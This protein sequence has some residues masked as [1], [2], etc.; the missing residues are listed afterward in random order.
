MIFAVPAAGDWFVYKYWIEDRIYYVVRVDVGGLGYT[1]WTFRTGWLR[2][3]GE[4]FGGD[5]HVWRR[6]VNWKMPA[7]Q[8]YEVRRVHFR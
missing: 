3:D 2:S 8:F 7:P 6:W 4:A 1:S 5:F